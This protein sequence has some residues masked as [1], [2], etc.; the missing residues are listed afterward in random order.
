MNR[1][2]AT[3]AVVFTPL[4]AQAAPPAEAPWVL[5]GLDINNGAVT[6]RDTAK[7]ADSVPGAREGLPA[8]PTRS[9]CVAALRHAIQKYAGLDH[10]SGNFGHYFCIDLRTVATSD[11]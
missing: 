8:Y 3:I 7:D 4:L 5:V 1:L 11:R 10:A 2:I 9:A 6:V